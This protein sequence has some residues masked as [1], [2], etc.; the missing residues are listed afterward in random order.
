MA[1]EMIASGLRSWMGGLTYDHIYN[2]SH[3]SAFKIPFGW[4]LSFFQIHDCPCRGGKCRG[5]Q[6]PPQ[7]PPASD[8]PTLALS[9]QHSQAGVRDTF[10][11]LVFKASRG[12]NNLCRA[13][14]SGASTTARL[15]PDHQDNAAPYL[16]ISLFNGNQPRLKVQYAP[17][18][19]LCL[20]GLL[21]DYCFTRIGNQT[22][23]QS[24]SHILLSS[25]S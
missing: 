21:L 25:M 20:F 2:S 12:L 23:G 13:N 17:G 4:N 15:V 18:A 7:P 16:R 5:G 1:P 11:A 3:I 10:K 9:Q 24:L 8:Q 6:P 22:A 19:F 14:P